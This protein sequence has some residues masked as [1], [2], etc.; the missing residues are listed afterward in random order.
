MKVVFALVRRG[1]VQVYGSLERGCSEVV[2]ELSGEYREVQW[3]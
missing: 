3:W 1:K 2:Y